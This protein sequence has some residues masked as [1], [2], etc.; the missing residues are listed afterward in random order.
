MDQYLLF[1]YLLLLCAAG[2]FRALV[3]SLGSDMR[4]LLLSN[5]LPVSQLSWLFFPYEGFCYLRL[6]LHSI[7]YELS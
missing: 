1:S 2:V 7:L 5:L 3:R 6:H 4:S